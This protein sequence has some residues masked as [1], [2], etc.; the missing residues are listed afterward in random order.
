M[1]SLNIFLMNKPTIDIKQK[2]I[3]MKEISIQRLLSDFEKLHPK[4]LEKAFEYFTN[5]NYK[6]FSLIE[7]HYCLYGLNNS[8]T[9]QEILTAEQLRTYT[10]WNYDKVTFD[11][12]YDSIKD[13]GLTNEVI[14]RKFIRQ[15]FK[16][17]YVKLNGFDIDGFFIIT[18]YHYEIDD[19]NE[20]DNNEVFL[21]LIMKIK[22]IITPINFIIN[23]LDDN[24]LE[25]ILKSGWH[26]ITKT[27]PITDKT[28]P[29][30]F[31]KIIGYATISLNIAY[32]IS[33]INSICPL[34]SLTNSKLIT[35]KTGNIIPQPPM[36]YSRNFI[37]NKTSQPLKLDN[38]NNDE[39]IIS[40]SKHTHVRRGHWHSFWI[41]KRNSSDRRLIIKWV[42]STIVN[43]SGRDSLPMLKIKV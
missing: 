17:Y 30:E 37:L 2:V 5:N 22:G 27:D 23:L 32:Y 1:T 38:T 21:S 12:D 41:D 29:N 36:D 3:S 18:R 28:S 25:S 33:D 14:K 8:P 26:R 39:R 42:D 35:D 20:Y 9:K 43:T 15:P 40:T 13:M 6:N 4:A 24:N 16:S 11:I 19:Y 34:H 10:L 7:A 31:K